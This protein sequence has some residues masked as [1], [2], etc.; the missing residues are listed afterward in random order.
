MDGYQ[1]TAHLMARHEEFAILRGFKHLNYQNLL[2]LQAEISYLEEDLS[3]LAERDR[4]S[5]PDRAKNWWALAHPDSDEDESTYRR[6][7]TKV[8]TTLPDETL[9]TN[10]ERMTEHFQSPEDIDVLSH[11]QGRD[12]SEQWRKIKELRKALNEYNDAL[13]KQVFLANMQKPNPQDLRFLRSWFVRPGMGNIPIIGADRKAWDPPTEEDLVA[14]K[15][16]LTPDHIS[17]WFSN[18]VFPFYHRDPEN[19]DLGEG[20]YS[21]QEP[22]LVTLVDIT[23]TVVAAV[24]PLLSTV[25]LYFL[26]TNPV[27]LGA[28]VAFS[29]IFALALAIMTNARRV[30]VFAATAAFA[31]VN[32]VFLTNTVSDVPS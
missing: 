17:R 7:S 26:Q 27:K 28:T 21:Y 23:V 10:E 9:Q 8:D 15:P 29:S 18:T 30:E 19:A 4:Q 16:R 6:T 20:I 2:Y 32:V 11:E 22:R 24:L 25:V 12:G 31:A 3:D 1:K 13:F 14:I 5:H